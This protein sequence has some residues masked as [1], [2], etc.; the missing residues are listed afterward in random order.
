MLTLS[1]RSFKRS[2]FWVNG[3]LLCD[4]RF[5]VLK[6]KYMKKTI[7]ATI[8]SIA[9]SFFAKAQQDT[10]FLNFRSHNEISDPLHYF[11][12]F[13]D[14][15]T[16]RLYL[17]K[18]KNAIVN[19]GATWNMQV[20]SNF[21]R[22]VIKWEHADTASTNLLK[23]F[24]DLSQIEVDLH[25]HFNDTTTSLS[26]NPYNYADLNYLIVKMCKMSKRNNIGG[27]FWEQASTWDALKTGL[28]CNYFS[29]PRGFTP[30]GPSYIPACITGGGSENDTHNLEAY[31]AWRPSVGRGGGLDF[32]K[33]D[34]TSSLLFL[35][36]GCHSLLKS[37]TN[38]DSVANEIIN[39]VNT[40]MSTTTADNNTNYT[41]SIMFNFR[42]IVGSNF[43]LKIKRIIDLLQPYVASGKIAWRTYT[44]KL[45]NTLTKKDP[46]SY[47]Q[48]LC[49]ATTTSSASRLSNKGS[50]TLSKNTITVYPNPTSSRININ[51]HSNLTLT[52]FLYNQLGQLVYSTKSNENFSMNIQSYPKGLFILKATDS[53]GK[54]VQTDKIILQ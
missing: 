35:G 31:G 4:Y 3:M 41:G 54:T 5:A 53:Q 26:Y 14:Y 23:R 17:N 47:F 34:S 37:T 33:N 43:D 32:L 10:L 20:E 48:K 30:V 45:A 16:S 42:D 39:F 18:I 49:S 46:S 27:F 7:T 8:I 15:D 28:L 50:N 29:V 9:I 24:D 11:D 19:G 1:E 6:L 52:Y 44:N 38:P 22:A 40:Y 51:N 21:I 12:N 25:N 13:A 2:F 36:D